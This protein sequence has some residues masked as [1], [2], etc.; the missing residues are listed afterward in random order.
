MKEVLWNYVTTNYPRKR[1]YSFLYANALHLLFEEELFPYMS[2][3]EKIQH[4]NMKENN[5]KKEVLRF[6]EIKHIIEILSST[7]I[8]PIF[9]KGYIL[10]RLLYDNNNVRNV[11]DLDFYVNKQFF[12]N[13][14]DLLK[15]NGYKIIHKDSENY[16]HHIALSKGVMY[17]E[18]HKNIIRPEL[19]INTEYM[20]NH[21]YKLNELI[22]TFNYTATLL[23]MFY[24]AYAHM[25][26]PGITRKHVFFNK[27]IFIYYRGLR[28][29]FE[30][31]M[32]IKKY[33]SH[34]NWD[35]FVID[36]E[37][38][39]LSI[40]FKELLTNIN[41]MFQNCIPDNIFNRL[42]NKNYENGNVPVTI[43]DIIN[44]KNTIFE[45]NVVKLFD[46]LFK[47]YWH[48][49]YILADKNK[50]STYIPATNSPFFCIWTEYFVI[51]NNDSIDL[52][53]RI[54]KK[55]HYDLIQKSELLF[56]MINFDGYYSSLEMLLE[57]YFKPCNVIV[58]KVNISMGSYL[59]EK[60]IKLEYIDSKEQINLS[61][62]ISKS[63]LNID[64]TFPKHIYA[65][66]HFEE[67]IEDDIQTLHGNYNDYTYDPYMFTKIVYE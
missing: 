28:N 40:Y 60:N 61:I 67:K 38:Q 8:T 55:T 6:C 37:K 4:S 5:L 65:D 27:N 48:G 1:Y 18:L 19:N 58:K 46:R 22:C 36:I 10:S 56:T 51:N 50:Y 11:G 30:I 9:F 57:V 2:D 34:I 12:S 52:N 54:N 26:S 35:D 64:S 25:E 31:A 21:T 39:T 32:F 63:L 24:H 66:L 17:I 7:G 20:E 14:L 43:G 59:D 47:Q 44:I 16:E 13:A 45:I 33:E 23:M 49:Y 3:D 42:M 53:I 41:L 62:S 29:L 15:R